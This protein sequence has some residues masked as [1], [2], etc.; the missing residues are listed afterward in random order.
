MLYESPC[1]ESTYYEQEYPEQYQIYLDAK[2]DYEIDK[3]ED[4]HF[5]DDNGEIYEII[6][7]STI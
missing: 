6:W 5:Y 2:S 7:E 3:Y 4:G 1:D